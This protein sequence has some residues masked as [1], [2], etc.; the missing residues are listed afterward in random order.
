MDSPTYLRHPLLTAI[1]YVGP[2]VEDLTKAPILAG[3]KENPSVSDRDIVTKETVYPVTAVP[4]PVVSS[5]SIQD[6]K[7]KTLLVVEGPSGFCFREM[8]RYI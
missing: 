1:K 3:G 5:E 2:L 4:L 8:L 6:G 7:Y